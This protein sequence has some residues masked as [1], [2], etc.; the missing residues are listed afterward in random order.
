MVVAVGHHV[1]SCLG[2]NNVD[3]VEWRDTILLIEDLHA[4]V[5][6]VLRTRPSQRWRAI[7]L[8]KVER[9]LVLGGAEASKQVAGMISVR[10][11]KLSLDR[12]VLRR[13]CVLT[14]QAC[15]S[16]HRASMCPDHS[17][18]YN[19]LNPHGCTT[20]RRRQECFYNQILQ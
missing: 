11:P 17:R 19:E 20:T 2:G 12:D 15:L 6:W 8:G 14:F 1:L 16:S 3:R 9:P 5:T 18:G 10:E 7:V 13:E 4:A